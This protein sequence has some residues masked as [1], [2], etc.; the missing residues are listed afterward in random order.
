MA[1]TRVRRSTRRH[2]RK[3]R[4]NADPKA[5]SQ[6]GNSWSEQLN[7]LSLE[8]KAPTEHRLWAAREYVAK[9]GDQLVA[10]G[11]IE[12]TSA[13]PLMASVCNA[14][15]I[16]IGRPETAES[17]RALRIAA[18]AL[19]KTIPA[20]VRSFERL[21]AVP[22]PKERSQ[23]ATVWRDNVTKCLAAKKDLADVTNTVVR[24]LSAAVS[25]PN[26]F[27][28]RFLVNNAELDLRPRTDRW[29]TET[30]RVLRRADLSTVEGRIRAA[31]RIVKQCA[32]ADGMTATQA[33]NLFKSDK[34]ALSGKEQVKKVRSRG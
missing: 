6:W 14:L 25:V 16:I 31:T 1:P 21:L 32:Q 5:L 7:Q 13:A 10:I 29:A 24:T 3:A 4:V 17:R 27:G 22:E 23:A 12:S 20:E 19:H 30:L 11:E 15:R 28:S 33:K 9:A 2:N 26:F 34:I 8:D 18:N